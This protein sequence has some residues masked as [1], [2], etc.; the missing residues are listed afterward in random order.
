MNLLNGGVLFA[1]KQA[2]TF[3]VATII[4]NTPIDGGPGVYLNNVDVPH[5]A[6]SPSSS[7]YLLILGTTVLTMLVAW[8]VQAS[9]LGIGLFAIHDDEDVAEVM[10]VPTLRYK[11]VAFAISGQG[12]DGCQVGSAWALRAGYDVVLPYYRDTGVLL[13]LGMTPVVTA[14]LD[15]PYCLREEWNRLHAADGRYGP[16]E[17]RTATYA[18]PLTGLL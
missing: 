12:H 4:L 5:L 1:G 6:P 17:T 8:R 18:T 10:G 15:D 7:I 3:V 16:P 14:Q 9:K 11:L 2:V 13:T